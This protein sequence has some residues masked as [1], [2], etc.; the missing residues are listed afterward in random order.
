MVTMMFRMFETTPKAYEPS[1][2]LAC[3]ELDS[4]VGSFELPVQADATI[5]PRRSVPLQTEKVQR[6]RFPGTEVGNVTQITQNMFPQVGTSVD[7]P[8]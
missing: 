8:R 3:V 7:V 1:V 5:H 4:K 6:N 2:R